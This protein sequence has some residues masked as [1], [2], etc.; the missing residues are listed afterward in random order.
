MFVNFNSPGAPSKEVLL[1]LARLTPCLLGQPKLCLQFAKGRST[2]TH[3]GWMVRSIGGS[4]KEP[5]AK[6]AKD[7]NTHILMIAFRYPFS[8]I[9]Q[10]KQ[11]TCFPHMNRWPSYKYVFL[12]RAFPVVHH[13]YM[14]FDECIL[15]MTA[16]KYDAT[17]DLSLRPVNFRRAFEK[18]SN[19]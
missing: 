3:H 4:H 19:C 1:P 16:S 7:I 8:S 5:G 17:A 2:P 6:M 13:M 18:A 12:L 11:A 9:R 14:T 15:H 10:V